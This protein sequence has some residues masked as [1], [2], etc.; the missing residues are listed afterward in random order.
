MTKAGLSPKVSSDGSRRLR[1]GFHPNGQLWQAPASL[2]VSLPRTTVPL[3]GH[4]HQR[5]I[6]ALTALHHLR[7]APPLSQPPGAPPRGEEDPGPLYTQVATHPGAHSV[8]G[9][10]CWDPAG[11]LGL[12]LL[13]EGN[14]AG[15]RQSCHHHHHHPRHQYPRRQGGAGKGT[16]GFNG[17]L[18][19]V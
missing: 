3:R 9:G 6:R 15:Q 7:I 10:G 12:V 13:S 1:L 17:C 18:S 14:S 8:P 4:F 5:H 19:A 11:S 16:V 2:R